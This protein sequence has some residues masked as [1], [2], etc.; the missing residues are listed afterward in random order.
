ML[1]KDLEII[2]F[3]GVKLSLEVNLSPDEETVKF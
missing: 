3:T 1:E 2:N